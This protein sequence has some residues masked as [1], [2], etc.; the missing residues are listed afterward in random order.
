MLPRWHIILGAIFTLIIWIFSPETKLFH[1]SL[2]FLSSFL[3]DFDHYLVALANTK[4]ISLRKSSDYFKI[5]SKKETKERKKKIK[6]KG[7]LYI[8]HTLEFHILILISSLLR[9][10]FFYIFLGM[11]FHSLLDVVWM[12]KS[13]RIYRREYFFINWL[14]KNFK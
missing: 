4:K 13:D 8:F 3:I 12:I 7:P 6:N 2:I 9:I 11:I 10:E 5:L 1:L 14:I